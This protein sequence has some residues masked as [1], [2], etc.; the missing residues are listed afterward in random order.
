MIQR[1]YT[2]IWCNPAQ[3]GGFGK[4]V[5]GKYPR[6]QTVDHPSWMAPFSL[7]DVTGLTGIT[8]GLNVSS[9]C[10][11]KGMCPSTG[12]K[13]P[14]WNVTHHLPPEWAEKGFVS[15]VD[16]KKVKR[17]RGEPVRVIAVPMPVPWHGMLHTC[18]AELLEAQESVPTAWALCSVFCHLPRHCF[19]GSL[20]I[21][22][23]GLLS[24]TVIPSLSKV[25][26][27]VL[28]LNLKRKCSPACY[29]YRSAWALINQRG[30][31]RVTQSL[32]ECWVGKCI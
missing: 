21:Y 25:W 8:P 24:H 13:M 1:H 30:S 23:R 2:V 5:Y 4:I 10:R 29:D 12:Q 28:I 3:G 14:V 17:K 9:D 11:S 18:R 20:D 15:L 7:E 16:D 26:T 22:T 27:P 19:L 31:S 32:R 6:Q